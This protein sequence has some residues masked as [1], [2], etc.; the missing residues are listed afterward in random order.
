MTHVVAL[1]TAAVSYAYTA[2]VSPTQEP[3]SIIPGTTSGFTS[4]QT[5]WGPTGL[6]NVPTAYTIGRGQASVGASF[7]RD[8]RG[9]TVNYSP[10]P[11]IEVGGGYIERD[12]F[13]GK[14][15]ANG[16]VLIRPMNFRNVELGIGM[17][18]MADA[19]NQ[20]FY[21]IGSFDLVA[22]NARDDVLGEAFRLKVHAGYGTGIY[23]DKVIGGGELGFSNKVALVAEWD[24]VDTNASIRY[25]PNNDITM[26]VGVMGKNLF[27]GITSLFRP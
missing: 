11:D 8:R 15:I 13:D 26:Q 6:I 23:R 17:I 1:A 12:G 25:R 7:S 20:T 10:V 18:D 24:G 5:T 27:F 14:A 19:I 2:A 4:Q 9:P 22:P 3:G 16:K 21:A